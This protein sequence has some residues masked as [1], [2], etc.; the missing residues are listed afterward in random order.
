MDAALRGRRRDAESDEEIAFHLDMQAQHFERSGVPASEAARLARVAFGSRTD[1]QERIREA[2]GT[3]AFEQVRADVSYAFRQ[4]RRSPGFTGTVVAVLALGIGA[5]AAIYSVVDRVLFRPLPFTNAERL[6]VVW[7]TDRRSGTTRE[8]ASWPDI[9]DIQERAKSLQGSAAFAGVDMSLTSPNAPPIRVTGIATTASFFSLTGTRPVLGR[10]F[11]ESESRPGGPRVAMLGESTWRSQFGGDPSVI[12]RTVRV[13]DVAYEIVGVVPN[14]TDVG[15][16]QIHELAAYHA[17]YTGDGEAGVWLPL[18]ASA[19]EFP[20]A[21]HPFFLLGRLS[22]GSSVARAQ[23]ELAGIASDLERTYRNENAERGV[24]VE[25]LSDVV[26]GPSRPL[27]YLLLAAVGLVLLVALA[28]VANLM[29]ARG[30]S[31]GREI[32]IRNALGATAPRVGRQLLVESMVL[33]LIGG[34]VGVLAAGVMLKVLL[35]QAPAN[36]PRIGDVS[37][38]GRVIL[39]S[40]VATLLVGLGCGVVPM[41]QAR[42]LAIVPALKGDAAAPNVHSRRWSSR[43]LLVVAAVALAVTLSIGANMLTRSFRNLMDADPGFQASSI[44]KAEFQLPPSR[45]PRDMPK[46]PKLPEIQQFNASLLERARGIA[47]VQSVALAAAHPLDAGFTNSWVIVG[48]EAEAKDFPEI[49]VRAVSPSYFETVGGKLVRG[50]LLSMSDDADAP[51]TALINETTAKRFFATTEA[52]GSQIRFWGTSRTIVGIVRDERIHGLRASTPPAIY[53]PIAQVPPS[54]GVLLA[55]STSNPEVLGAELQRA[56]WSI[57]PQLAVYGVEPFGKTV[58]RSVAS[59]RFAMLV[60]SVFAVTTA[61][62]ALIGIHGVVRYLA[63]QRTKEIGIRMALGARRGEVIGLM[64]RS[65]VGL[66][67]LGVMVGVIGAWTLSRLLRTLL[68]G[69]GATDPV[70]FIGVAVV[71]LLATAASAYL[72]ARRAAR[73]SPLIAIRGA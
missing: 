68:Y 15:I 73:T 57:D 72:P 14:G 70:S 17:P 47:G 65:G 13:D 53:V 36:I 22:P 25:A 49:S 6:V 54:G 26:F 61:L 56:I 1:A 27:L 20:R 63:T 2:R 24:H 39:L 12:G 71:M 37:V 40:L 18:Q 44:V 3:A 28:N 46:W 21:T 16:D 31:R 5:S 10:A 41:W 69:V 48:R 42:R 33:G 52:L 67:V 64:V 59:N 35:A 8:P 38:D 19:E 32:A 29:L 4:M 50:R 34:A 43:E 45:Y 30:A 23:S 11:L 60:L 51:S 58:L 7:E 9:V 62:L 66:A 55:R